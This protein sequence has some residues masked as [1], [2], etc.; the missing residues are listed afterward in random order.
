[1]KKILFILL[2]SLVACRKTTPIPTPTK[3]KIF[4]V[5]ENSVNNGQLIYFDLPA[6]GIYTFTL[7]DKNSGQI[8]SKERFNGLIGENI[9][10]IYT[11]SLPVKI[12]YLQ[13]EDINKKEIGK[14][15]ITI[16]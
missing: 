11:K 9:K 1:M 6:T 2:L 14:T 5:S 3:L 8:I 16:N 12:L 4:S 13:L 10:K 7:I 15:T